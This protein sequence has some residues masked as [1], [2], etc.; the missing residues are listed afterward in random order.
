MAKKPGLNARSNSVQAAIDAGGTI[1][2]QETAPGG[3]VKL[4]GLSMRLDADRH[5]ALRLIAFQE[6]CSLHSL[7]LEGVDRIIK[8]RR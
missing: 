4:I 1:E 2:H 6:R 7:L 5:E 8:N 3:T